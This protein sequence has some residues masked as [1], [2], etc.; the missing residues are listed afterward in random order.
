MLLSLQRIP[1]NC[2]RLV[3]VGHHEDCID[4]V[5]GEQRA[6]ICVDTGNCEFFRNAACE[7]RAQVGNSDDSARRIACKA[8]QMRQ[9]PDPSGTDDSNA[10]RH[11]FPRESN[12]NYFSI[13]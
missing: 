10:N 6:V 9:L 12:L 7:F 13:R 4:A 1:H 3:S 2:R 8:L 5:I 11:G